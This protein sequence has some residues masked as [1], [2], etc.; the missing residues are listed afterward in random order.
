MVQQPVQ[1]RSGDHRIAGE[2]LRPG[3]KPP[4]RRQD[5]RSLLIE[6]AGH[7]EEQVRCARLQAQV[8]QFI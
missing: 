5:Q 3:L 7:L 6:T 4:V 8:A 1:D 2:D